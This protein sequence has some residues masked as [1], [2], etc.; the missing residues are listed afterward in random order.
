MPSD[1]I[2][3]MLAKAKE[4]EKLAAALR[5]NARLIRR[6][7]PGSEVVADGHRR[8]NSVGWKTADDLEKILE[9]G[10]KFIPRL[11]LEDVLVTSGCVEGQTEE[12]KRSSAKV[13]LTIGLA[14][15]YLIEAPRGI[16]WVPGLRKSRARK[17][18]HETTDWC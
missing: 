1:L 6:L 4:Y 7:E 10:N 11:E 18:V 15:G 5:E 12:K 17:K 3:A 2:E 16:G 14:N 13:A 9:Y 8:R